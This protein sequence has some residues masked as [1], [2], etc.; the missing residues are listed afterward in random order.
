MPSSIPQLIGL[1]V[2]TASR[3]WPGVG[4]VALAGLLWMAGWSSLLDRTA[5]PREALQQLQAEA[6]HE[7]AT[8]PAAPGATQQKPVQPTDTER[9]R[10]ER[11]LALIRDWLGRA[12]PSLLILVLVGLVGWVWL[13]GGQLG[14]L[15]TQLHG[16]ASLQVLVDTGRRAF[17]PVVQTTGLMFLL[18]A[19][20]LAVFS[21]L[22]ALGRLVGG[23]LG[24]FLAS[25]V[26]VGA[27]TAFVWIGVMVAFWLIAVVLDRTT[28]IAG[29]K[30][31]IRAVR[32]RW[33]R[34]CGLL[35]LW[36]LASV[37]VG[38]ILQLVGW[39]L[40]LG[41]G[42]GG[43]TVARSVLEVVVNAWIG[44]AINASLMTRYRQVNAETTP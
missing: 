32:G 38:L 37:A 22:I 4:V 25:F 19:G 36:V 20:L 21:V 34:T 9:E 40:G 5:F 41:L 29:L 13:I 12:W 30:A 26:Q 24:F 11:G 43:G 10:M 23:G 31:S 1:G 33:W 8:T 15:D 17:L 16:R 18:G 28:P 6:E 14:Y 27:V 2:K 3:S 39:L 7:L 42:P 35:S 44:F